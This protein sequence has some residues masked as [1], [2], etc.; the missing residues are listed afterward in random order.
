ADVHP[1]GPF[2]LGIEGARMRVEDLEIESLALGG[3]PAQF[4]LTMMMAESDDGL[5]AA[6]QYNADLFDGP[7]IDRMLLHFRSLLQAIVADP[8]R[9]VTSYP[10]L[11]ESERQLVLVDWNQTQREYPRHLCLHDLIQEQI[12]RT[13]GAV[14][15]EFDEERL[16][17][18][19]L[20]R[21]AAQVA[22][23]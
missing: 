10:L 4:D 5:A 13:P 8:V 18:Q 14:A 19:D 16:T 6:L 12:V 2:A 9:P 22:A 3:E 23:C 7:T 17:Y 1:L 11:A 20:D 15:I 21:R